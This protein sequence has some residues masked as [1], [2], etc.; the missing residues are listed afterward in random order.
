[1]KFKKWISEEPD[2]LLK[3]KLYCRN[4]VKVKSTWAVSLV[5][6]WG[7]FLKWTRKELKLMDQ[8]TRKLMTIHKTLHLRDVVDILY[9]SRRE[10]GRGLSSI[11]DSEGTS[12]QRLEDYM[13]NRREYLI[14]ATSHNTD[15]TRTS[16]ARITRKQKWEVKQ[17]CRRFKL[18]TSDVAHEK[19]WTWLRKW[20]FKRETEYVLIAAKNNAIR[21]N[22]IKARI[23]K[24]H[25]NT[26]CRLCSERE[27]MINHIISEFSKLAQ[28][29]YKI[30]HDWMG[31]MIHLELCHKLK[32][33]NTEKMVN[34][35]TQICPR[36]WNAQTFGRFW[37]K[38]GSPNPYQ[39]TR[40]YNNQ[41]KEGTWGIVD[42]DV[43]ATR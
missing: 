41:Q 12:I 27:E 10:R 7:P 31:T 37:D 21:T 26:R 34:A 1:M 20:N 43:P 6:Y 5:R 28:K 30:R 36:E 29:G 17:L 16:R 39:M 40:S 33:Y 13:Q 22:H 32:F 42:F 9:M 35:Q 24:T 11:E 38:N 2:K 3:R 18:Q 15:D 14:T 23:G 19:T 8:R 25:Q 4:I